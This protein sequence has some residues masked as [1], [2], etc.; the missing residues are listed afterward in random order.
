MGYLLV[1]FSHSNATL[2]MREKLTFSDEQHDT[3]LSDLT[4]QSSINEAILI[5]TCNR[6]ALILSINSHI[7]A[8]KYLFEYLSKHSLIS[9]EELEGVANIFEDNGAIH[10]LFSVASSLESIVVGE[11]QIA[12]QLKEAF[13]HA[14]EKGF[15]SKEL[16][17]V[18][19]YAFKCAAEVRN[20]TE[21]SKNKVSVASVAIAMAKNEL[22]DLAGKKALVI[23]VGEMSL[24]ATKHLVASGAQVSVTNRTLES[25]KE[26]A[27][28]CGSEVSVVPFDD[29]KEHLNS[30]ELLFTST[31]SSEPIIT[32]SMINKAPN[33][34]Y[35]FD[36]AVP[37][38]IDEECLCD[39]INLYHI[40][41]LKSIVTQNKALRQEE[42]LLAH[43]IIGRYSMEFFG[44]LKSLEIEPVLKQLYNMAEN[45]AQVETKRVIEKGFIPEEHEESLQKATFQSMKRFLHDIST[46]LRQSASQ[47]SSDTTL[48]ALQ[49]LLGEEN[50]PDIYQREHV[51]DE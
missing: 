2:S 37:R 44:W 13:A 8:Q 15:C 30:H 10:H 49:Y 11:T 22:G 16:S 32:S 48:Q 41:D 25:A 39:D 20:R 24:L 36:M 43:E 38:D 14:H 50:A 47:S 51:K 6:M 31:S 9:I 12:G 3:A 23:G 27:T 34:R 21:I 46:R 26:L 17:R 18:M 29:L 1:S 28:E 5:N 40:D 19:H 45:A 42:T 33:Q 7:E 35:W 4:S